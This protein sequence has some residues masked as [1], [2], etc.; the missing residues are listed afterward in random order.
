MVRLLR[1][2]IDDAADALFETNSIPQLRSFCMFSKYRLVRPLAWAVCVLGLVGCR[3][4]G[5][6]TGTVSG[7]VTIGGTAPGEPIRVQYINSMIG[8]GGSATTDA[9][10]NYKL[11]QPIQVAE[12]TIYFEKLVDSSQPV[13]TSAEQLKSVAKEYRN[14]TTSP[15]KKKIE[16]GANKIDLDVPKG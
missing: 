5:P 13:S 6:P 2:R 9:E 7:K 14:E 8:Q 11:N 3:D 4:S 10:G 1:C 12:Y 16:P 15:L